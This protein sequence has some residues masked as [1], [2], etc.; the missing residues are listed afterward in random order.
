MT[1]RSGGP[2]SDPP[3]DAA[4]GDDARS[5]GLPRIAYRDER[6]AVIV[7][8]FGQ[9]SEG[10]PDAALEVA[11]RAL[12]WPEARLPHR[13]DRL[14]RGFLVIARDAESVAWHNEAIRARRWVKCYIA[15][16][17]P[18]GAREGQAASLVGRHKAYLRRVGMRSE[19]VRSGGD[20]S[21][22]EVLAVAPAPHRPGETHAAIRLETG[23]FHQIRVM[24]AALDAPLTSDRTYGERTPGEPMLEHALCSIPLPGPAPTR[25]LTLFNAQDPERE[26]V[27][28]SVLAALAE[29]AEL[30]GGAAVADADGRASATT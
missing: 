15:R 28:A 18:R 19:V 26:P 10:A 25:T 24:L 17:H 27:D 2:P 16:L 21:F 9:S 12:A 3:G 23:R 13:L 6:T 4:R 20:P 7:K 30:A 22:L 14:T 11:R 8:P 5:S 29:L 1:R